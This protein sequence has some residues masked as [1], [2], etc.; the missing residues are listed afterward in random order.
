MKAKHIALFLLVFVGLATI[1]STAQE[2]I[3]LR[4]HPQS[5]LTYNV[6]WKETTLVQNRAIRVNVTNEFN[7]D[8]TVKDASETQTEI[9]ALVK[10]I[11]AQTTTPMRIGNV[12][13]DS[14]H[15][16]R[17]N[18][19]LAKQYDPLLN[20]AFTVI[21]DELG[22][23]VKDLSEPF[24]DMLSKVYM[25]VFIQLP[26]EKISVGSQWSFETPKSYIV[27]NYT[28]TSISDQSVEVSFIGNLDNKD[29]MNGEI[30][31]TA[32]IHPQTGMVTRSNST[33][34]I[35]MKDASQPFP[36]TIEMSTDITVK[37][38]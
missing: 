21:Y 20:E 28:V 22:N 34:T 25:H 12:S 31:G 16:R 14:E 17:N 29:G 7:Q 26:E 13:Y 3:T 33:S 30:E 19:D 35:T 5:D 36:S 11:K 4:L 10:S 37:E 18:R 27:W 32:S 15:P 9:E 6:E 2:S 23:T 1:S 38:I 8:L 24:G